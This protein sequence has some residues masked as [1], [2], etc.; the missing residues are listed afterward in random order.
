MSLV[1]FELPEEFDGVTYESILARMMSRIPD[2]YDKTEGGFVHDMIAPTA[3]EVAEL[4]Q[5]WLA[6]GI[7]TNFHMWA[8]GRWLDYHAHD[9]GLIRKEATHAYATLEVTTSGTVKFPKGFVFC[10]PSDDNNPALDFETTQAYM[11]TE[12]GTHEVR[13]MAVDAGTVGNVA[14]GSIVLMKNPVKGVTNIVNREA[15]SG[16]VEAEGDD[17]LR[18]R[19]DAFYAGHGA[20]YVGNKADYERWARE[21]AGVGF[22]HCIP[23]FNGANTVKVV[24]ADEDGKP[25]VQ[26]ILDAVE[27]YIFGTGHDDPNRLAPI[28]VVEYAVVPSVDA[29]ITL[30]LDVK[31]VD[32]SSKSA[33]KKR[34]VKAMLAHFQSLSDTNN[35]YADLRYMKVAAVIGSVN[36]VEDFRNL[37]VNGDVVNISFTE[38]QVPTIDEEHITLNDWVD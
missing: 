7:K 25:A 8:K 31:L 6:L 34:I 5:F 15:A 18:E 24:I 26:E 11:F 22:A 23:C 38:D 30:S 37:L 1:K 36:G 19:I 32:G 17:S 21:I 28:G 10:V 35:Y 29:Q 9:C 16:G 20:S 2:G 14:A 12:D 3:L 13:V 4:I 33:V 27:T